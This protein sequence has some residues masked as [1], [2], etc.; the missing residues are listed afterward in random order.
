MRVY[1]SLISA[2]RESTPPPPPLIVLKTKQTKT[3]TTRNVS[4]S[5]TVEN[6]TDFRITMPIS[7]SNK[8]PETRSRLLIL[9]C[10]TLFLSGWGGWWGLGGGGQCVGEGDG[11]LCLPRELW[12]VGQFTRSLSR[13]PHHCLPLYPRPPTTVSLSIPDPPP[14][15]HRPFLLS[16]FL[17]SSRLL[18]C[19]SLPC[20]LIFPAPFFLSL[21]PSFFAH[22]LILHPISTLSLSCFLFVCFCFIILFSPFF[23]Y[24]VVSKD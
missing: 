13:C 20:F 6:I 16:V 14:P 18:L 5:V 7:R 24:S 17:S 9:L 4:C 23:T 2:L 21:S 12:R 3:T 22:S 15:P 10:C 11:G 1:C 8:G 19:P